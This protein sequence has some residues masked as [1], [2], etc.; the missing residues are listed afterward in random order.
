MIPKIKSGVRK[1]AKT[2]EHFLKE[3]KGLIEGES[4]EWEFNLQ[5]RK[6]H[7][8]FISPTKVCD[9]WSNKL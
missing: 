8:K 4:G 3:G 9:V 6:E 7:K 1:R 5:A 2:I